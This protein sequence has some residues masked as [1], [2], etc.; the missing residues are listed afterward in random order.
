MTAK[1]VLIGFFDAYFRKR[2]LN[3]SLPFL[4]ENINWIGSSLKEYANNKAEITKLLNAWLLMD[5][6]PYHYMISDFRENIVSENSSIFSLNLEISQ[7]RDPQ[8]KTRYHISS[9]IAMEDEEFRIMSVHCSI[10]SHILSENNLFS[11]EYQRKHKEEEERLHNTFAGLYESCPFGVVIYTNTQIPKL[12]YCNEIGFY[13]HGLVN[14]DFVWRETEN[15]IKSIYED[16]QKTI[17]NYAATVP[18]KRKRLHFE[19]PITCPDSF[20]RWIKGWIAPNVN[21]EGKDFLEAIFYDNTDA[22]NKDLL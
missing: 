4:S 1:D 3:E 2:N 19:F 16:Y 21:E 8:I 12:I 7:E 6:E 18:A 15:Y 9:A 20:T 22:K 14:N 5:K 11:E 13:I 10:P 17:R